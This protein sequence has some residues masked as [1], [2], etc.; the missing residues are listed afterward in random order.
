MLPSRRWGWSTPLSPGRH[1]LQSVRA[2]I[3]LF[4]SEVL[5]AGP[6]REPGRLRLHISQDVP[7]VSSVRRFTAS[8]AT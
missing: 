6:R 5:A 1:D 8:G 2:R 7:R 3:D 4:R